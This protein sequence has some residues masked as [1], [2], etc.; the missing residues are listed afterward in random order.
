MSPGAQ[1]VGVKPVVRGEKLA[2]ETAEEFA[3]VHVILEGLA[4]IDKDDRDLV[5]ELAAKFRIGVYIDFLPSESA[6]A[7]ELRQTLLHQLAEVTTFA[8]VD[9]DLP[10]EF[11]GWIVAL[12]NPQSQREI[13]KDCKESG[14]GF[15]LVR[16][17]DHFY[18]YGAG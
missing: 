1:C 8:G 2:G 13:V 16:S 5:V 17:A 6:V 12:G 18:G 10:E 9:D 4:A 15:T 3:L 14:V 7:S 11:H